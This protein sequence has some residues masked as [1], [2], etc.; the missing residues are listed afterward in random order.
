[1]NE[2][3]EKNFEKNNENCIEWLNGSHTCTCTFTSRKHINRIKKLYEEHKDK[4]GFLYENPDGSVCC[5]IP[6]KW[7]KVNPGGNREYTDE[8]RAAMADRMRIMR[9]KI[10]GTDNVE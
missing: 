2:D 8:Q 4:F 10:T 9:S 6:L 5:K 3:N 7:I 1:M